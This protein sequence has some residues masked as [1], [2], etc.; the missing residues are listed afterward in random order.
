MKKLLYA[1]FSYAAAGVLS[2]LYYRELTKAN[3]FSGE[4]QLGLVHTHWLVLGFIVLLIALVLERVFRISAVAPK[5]SAWFFGVWNAGVVITGGMMLVKGTM[6]VAGADASSKALSG[7][8]GMG[9]ILLT[10][11]L[12]LLFLALRKAVLAQ[13]SASVTAG[14]ASAGTADDD[15]GGRVPSSNP[16]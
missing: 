6:V 10:A 7:I 5:L 2:G 12:V 1:S 11:G 9:H 8:A 3:D 16:A 14:T 15:G 13:L 4:S